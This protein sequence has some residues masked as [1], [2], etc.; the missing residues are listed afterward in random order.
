MILKDYDILHCTGKKLLS[1]AIRKATHSQFSHSAIYRIIEG[2][3]CVFDAQIDGTQIRTFDKWLKDY[4]YK[5]VATRDITL[6]AGD[7]AV[8]K[9]RMYRNLDKGYDFESLI[10]RQPIKLITGKWKQR[11]NEDSRLY[12]SELVANIYG[13]EYSERMSPQDL[14]MWCVNQRHILIE[15]E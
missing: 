10:I 1:T 2:V 13:A 4:D 6:N 8:M 15:N 14:F 7:F 12:C 9:R 3:P 11:K 5:F